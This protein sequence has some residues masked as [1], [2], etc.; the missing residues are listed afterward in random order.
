MRSRLAIVVV[1]AL[2]LIAS[3]GAQS[4]SGRKDAID[5]KISRLRSKIEAA[6]RREGVLTSEISAVTAKIRVLEG[7]VGDATARLATLESE[8]ELYRERLDRVT[9]LL[10]LQTQK[11]ELMKS[12][13]V[14]AQRR[15]NER[16][17]AIYQSDDPTTVE[18]VLAARS[19]GELL[20]QLEYRSEIGRQDRRIADQVAAAKRRIREARERTQTTRAKVAAATR[21]IG[22]RTRQQRAERDRLLANQNAL[23]SARADK[24]ETLDAV[25]TSKE[26]F[27]H[28]VAGLERASAALAATIR[29]AQTSGPVY[30]SG[31][32][33]YDST[34]SGAGLIW[35]VAGP[36]TSG[37]GW[38]WGRMHEGIDIAAPSGAPIQASASG[39]VIYAGWMDGYGN[40]VVV[41]HGNGLSTAY[42]HMSAIGVGGGQQ[43]GQGQ[44][45]GYVGCTGHCFGSHLHFEVRLNGSPVDPLGYL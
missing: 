27:L 9:E 44:V 1:L 16:I 19:L 43:V 17:V 28:E 22:V 21:A 6:E 33:S 5:E 23:A 38:R 42:A 8:L 34:P 13:H 18:V 37:F 39:V 25:Q 10:R 41:D 3:A 31:A 20:D 35:P 32:S 26:E 29:S 30:P 40:L 12:Q 45:I 4:P 7:E 36:V 2:T 14:L 24:R 15:L 11:L